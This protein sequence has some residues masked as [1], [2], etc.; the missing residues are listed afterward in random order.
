MSTSLCDR[1][2]LVYCFLAGE[3]NPD[4]GP[5]LLPGLGPA[6]MSGVR[7]RDRG[8]AA[9]GTCDVKLPLVE[10]PDVGGRQLWP[11]PLA[12]LTMLDSTGLLTG[13]G[14]RTAFGLDS[15]FNIWS[16]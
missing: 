1:N 16:S 9:C 10:P 11:V 14:V 13:A 6:D 2:V 15:F 3:Y 12:W 5:A 8:D 4:P 7:E